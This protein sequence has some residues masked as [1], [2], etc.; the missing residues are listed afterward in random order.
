MLEREKI[1]PH[2]G[3]EKEI[4]LYSCKG[5][6]YSVPQ[7]AEEFLKVLSPTEQAIV[8]DKVS[9]FPSMVPDYLSKPLCSNK[10]FK[11]ETGI[12]IH[13]ESV[14]SRSAYWPE[15]Q[16]KLKAC[17]PVNGLYF[18]HEELEF[19]STEMVTEQIAFGVLSAEGVMREI[20]AYCFF[21]KHQLPVLQKPIA[22]FEYQDNGQAMGYSVAM[23]S[24]SE[25]RL[26]AKED[27]KDLSVHDLIKLIMMEKRFNL[28]LL[29]KEVGFQ[30]TSQDWYLENKTEI[31]TKMNLYGGFRGFLNSNVGNDL[32]FKNRLYICD[33]D[34]FKVIEM[35][36]EPDPNF[37]KG[38]CIWILVEALKSS[39]LVWDYLNLD[40]LSWLEASECLWKSYSSKSLFWQTYKKKLNQLVRERGWNQTDVDELIVELTKSRLLYQLLIDNVA[41]STVIKETY[42]PEFSFYRPHNHN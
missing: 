26:E 32:V 19:G 27:F 8:R 38:F 18:P 4:T 22:I 40:G 33:F 14:G 31:L 30:D 9:V 10:E 41:N 36:K 11:D 24:P 5:T 35:P 34:T 6:V 1:T 13:V 16:L 23:E 17:R 21:T 2:L 15:K 7:F 20:L 28:E 39:P 25:A 29:E 42:K 3:Q 37:I 12:E